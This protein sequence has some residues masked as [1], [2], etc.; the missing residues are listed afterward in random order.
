MPGRSDADADFARR[1]SS[2]YLFLPFDL[3]LVSL[4]PGLPGL[5]F[6]QPFELRWGKQDQEHD[7]GAEEGDQYQAQITDMGAENLSFLF[8]F[9][10]GRGLHQGVLSRHPGKAKAHTANAA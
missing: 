4:F 8:G 3:F 10:A 6:F 9:V 7:D 5:G 2:I 1:H